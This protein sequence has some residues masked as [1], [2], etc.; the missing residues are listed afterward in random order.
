MSI[1][2]QK[3]TAPKTSFGDFIRETRQEIAKVTWPTR[4]ETLVMTSMIVVMALITGVF[5]LGI[6]SALGYIIGH[7]LGMN[8]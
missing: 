5:F 3:V 6:D 2:E 7:I 8:S 1:E 4:K